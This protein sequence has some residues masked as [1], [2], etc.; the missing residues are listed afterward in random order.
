M[1]EGKS[2]KEAR[3]YILNMV[4][5]YCGE[6]HNRPKTEQAAY[7]PYAGRVYDKEEMTALTD[8]ALDFWL[9]SGRYTD[10]FE[11][12]FADFL[13]VIAFRD[14]IYDDVYD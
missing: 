14:I 13:G 2:E 7:L 12:G 4:S 10:D 1:F 6:F 3:H 11:R 9:T 5:A 8:S